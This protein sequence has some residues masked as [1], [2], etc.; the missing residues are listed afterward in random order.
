MNL[1][2]ITYFHFS[3]KVNYNVEYPNVRSTEEKQL[4]ADVLLNRCSWKFGSIR[5]KT[6]VLDLFLMKLQA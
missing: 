1:S 6:A 3:L 4:F 5:K 2:T